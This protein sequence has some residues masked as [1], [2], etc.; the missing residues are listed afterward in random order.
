MSNTNKIIWIDDNPD[1]AKTSVD[2]GAEFIDVNR[3]AG[4]IEEILQI[5][6]AE[7]EP[8]LVILD[9]FL[10]DASSTNQLFQRGSTIAEA[11]KEQWPNCPVVGI[12]N[13][14][15]AG[16][17]ERTRHAYDEL[18]AFEKFGDHVEFLKALGGDFDCVETATEDDPKSIVKLV[19]PPKEEIPRLVDSMPT[20][21]KGDQI[22][23]GYS[24]LYYEWVRK[25]KDKPGFLYDDLWAATFIGLNVDGFA[26]VKGLF[27]GAMYD[28]I[29]SDGVAERWWQFSLREILYDKVRPNSGEYSWQVGRRLTNDEADYSVCHNCDGAFPETVAYLDAT[30]AERQPMHLNCTALHPR[31]NRELFFED[32]RIMAEKE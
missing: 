25:I 6:F 27:E 9:H 17:N 21:L 15:V 26:K 28:G 10:N 13:Y 2:I 12:T 22:G 14:D 20:P 30:S 11:I 19:K 31:F 8:S 29:F 24:S 5:F 4:N 32:I 3:K 23:Q 16:I 7:G 18:F 1:R